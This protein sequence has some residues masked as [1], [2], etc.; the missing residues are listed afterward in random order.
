MKG[1][2]LFEKYRGPGGPDW[3]VAVACSTL[4]AAELQTQNARRQVQSGASYYFDSPWVPQIHTLA[5]VIDVAIVAFA[6]VWMVFQLKRFSQTAMLFVAAL[7]LAL[8]WLE[9]VYAL[10]L[11][12]GTV[13]V[14]NGLPYQPVNNVGLIGAQVFGTY[15]VFKTPSGKVHGWRAWTVKLVLAVALWFFQSVVWQMVVPIWGPRAAA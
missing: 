2:L 13:F 5:L 8:C 12:S 6:G 3:L 11:Q 14:L 1:A 4:V 10:Q 7:G 9:L 15:L